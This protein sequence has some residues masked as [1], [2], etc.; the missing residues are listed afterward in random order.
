[1]RYDL[2]KFARPPIRNTTRRI[3]ENVVS[4]SM[5]VP[6]CT[7][8][9]MMSITLPIQNGTD[10]DTVLDIAKKPIAAVNDKNKKT[11]THK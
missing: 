6:S 3:D 1:M 8:V 9:L 10:K 2:A 4:L 5:R 11:M 7:D